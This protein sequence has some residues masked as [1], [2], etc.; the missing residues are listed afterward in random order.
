VKP[1]QPA[2]DVDA[3]WGLGSAAA[4]DTLRRR[5]FRGRRHDADVDKPSSE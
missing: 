5:N 4:L 1:P 3:T 2:R